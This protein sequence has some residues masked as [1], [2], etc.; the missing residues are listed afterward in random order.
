MLLNAEIKDDHYTELPRQQEP[1]YA[2]PAA[3]YLKADAATGQSYIDLNAAAHSYSGPWLRGHQSI[4]A[5][6]NDISID[7]GQSCLVPAGIADGVM[8]R[9]SVIYKNPD[10][11][12][13]M[14]QD[15]FEGV[16][17]TGP[18][19]RYFEG[20]TQHTYHS[21]DVPFGVLHLTGQLETPLTETLPYNPMFA[22]QGQN[23]SP[24]TA[25]YAPYETAPAAQPVRP[26]FQPA[27][28]FAENPTVSTA[29]QVAPDQVPDAGF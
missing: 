14:S 7:W 8:I 12:Y 2:Y 17:R 13:R 18:Q 23:S 3:K 16:L 5:S 29:D 20:Q 10:G 9:G 22:F 21:P 28:I 15:A 25:T 26:V 4:T 19:Y 1:Q 11:S 6:S 27:G 24:R